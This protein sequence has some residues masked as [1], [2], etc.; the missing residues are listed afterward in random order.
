[1]NV[2]PLYLFTSFQGR[3]N[4]GKYWLATLILLAISAV[5]EAGGQAAG[6]GTLFKILSII[7]TIA[8]TV[9]ALAV[10]VKRLHD[11]DKSGWWML[12]FYIGPALL[13]FGTIY[14]VAG[15][16]AGRSGG[17]G[18]VFVLAGFAVLIWAFIELG[19]LRGTV[20]P[21]R[22]GPDPLAGKV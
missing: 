21:N 8:S 19:C 14:G 5:L 9:A 18:L 4:R 2:D 10:A 17:G 6:Q 12:L 1:M 16:E 7:V 22:F 13:A 20:G 3:I 11:R 15:M